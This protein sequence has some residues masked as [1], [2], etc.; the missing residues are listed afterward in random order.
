MSSVQSF[1][2]VIW[3]SCT[4]LILGSMPG[5]ASLEKHQYYANPRNHF[6]PLIF[7]MYG[8]PLADHYEDRLS[9]ALDK[10]IALWDV[11]KSCHRPGSLDSDITSEEMNDFTSLY[12]T[13]PQIKTVFFNGTKA[14]QT[15]KKHV[16][17]DTDREYILLPSTSPTPS[18]YMKTMEDKRQK[19]DMVREFAQKK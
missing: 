11:I 9:F 16:G 17:F 14:Y 2:P 7:S 18:K 1:P 5:V 12:L 6:W 13:Y 15:Y 4:I 8:A 3:D 19:W 10:G